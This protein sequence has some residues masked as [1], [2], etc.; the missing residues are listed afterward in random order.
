MNYFLKSPRLGFGCWSPEDLPLAMELWGDPEVTALI[1][2]SFTPDMVRT[3]LATEIEQMRKYGMQYWPLFLLPGDQHV[4]CAGLRP[5]RMEERV[6]ELGIHLRRAFWRK[7]LAMEAG[8]AVIDYAFATLGAE[9][10]FA[11]HHPSNQASRELL[12]R[13]GFV[14]THDELYPPTGLMNPSYLLRMS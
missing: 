1:G 8:S 13:L 11:G 2:G 3:R 7:G 9:A 5:Y 4:G 6:Y 10:L 14:R 12:L